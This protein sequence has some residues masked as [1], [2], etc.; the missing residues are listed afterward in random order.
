MAILS[1]WLRKSAIVSNFKRVKEA[2]N[3]QSEKQQKSEP[4]E[5]G[6]A[7]GDTS[8]DE[9][10]TGDDD[11]FAHFEDVIQGYPPRKL[12]QASAMEEVK[13]DDMTEFVGS[14]STE[15]ATSYSGKLI[16]LHSSPGTLVIHY[17]CSV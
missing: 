1:N 12:S 17:Y 9:D 15:A 14:F 4:S 7:E 13:Y 16:D 11:D 5:A 2:I 10:S 6:K 8:E 3:R